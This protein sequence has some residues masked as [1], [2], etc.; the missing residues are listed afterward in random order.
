MWFTFCIQQDISR[1][2][3]SM[4][5]TVLM[6]VMNGPRYLCDELDPLPDRYRRVFN[7]FI[8]LA[9]LDKLHAEVALVVTFAHLVDWDDA[10][11]VKTPS[12]FCF[13]SETLEVR[14]GRP[15][16]HPDHF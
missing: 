8:K 12:S 2:N 11:V 4:Q 9:A 6:G 15:S 16:S 13:Q 14:A 7:Y 3:I 10:W 5:N 1:L